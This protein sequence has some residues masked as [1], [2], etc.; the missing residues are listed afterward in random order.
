MEN[1]I[2]LDK[3]VEFLVRD[4]M[5]DHDKDKIQFPFYLFSSYS[6][7]SPPLPL[8]TSPPT[9]PSS[10]FSKYCKNVYG[11]TNQEIE[12]V[13]NQYRTIILDKITNK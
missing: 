13:W 10:S 2:F 6:L 12:Y 1:N 11:L 3:V 9:L 8:L 5:I 7:T 4:T